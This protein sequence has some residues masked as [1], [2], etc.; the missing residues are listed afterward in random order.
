MRQ[1]RSRERAE[2]MFLFQVSNDAFDKKISLDEMEDE[3]ED[4][5]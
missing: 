1:M 4:S 3:E 2:L 5:E